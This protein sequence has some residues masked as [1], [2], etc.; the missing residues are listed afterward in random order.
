[1]PRDARSLTLKKTPYSSVVGGGMALVDEK[2]AY[3]FL[4][5]II[6]TTEGVTRE[7]TEAIVSQIMAQVK[8]PIVVAPRTVD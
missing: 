2:G 8:T 1:M 6:G 5:N 7:E 3:R 4:I